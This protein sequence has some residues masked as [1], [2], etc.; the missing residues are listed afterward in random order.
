MFTGTLCRMQAIV[1]ATKLDQFAR[2]QSELKPQSDESTLTYEL[3]FSP[4]EVGFES[5]MDALFAN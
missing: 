3:G 2:V 1:H 5:Q 4:Y